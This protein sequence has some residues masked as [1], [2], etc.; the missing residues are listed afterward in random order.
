MKKESPMQSA[1]RRDFLKTMGLG[2]AA[3]AF[4]GPF[5]ACQTN[6]FSQGGKRPN[7]LF[8]F[9]DD[10]TF[11]SIGA[12]NNPEIKTPNMDRLVKRG[13]TFTHAFNQGSFSGAVCIASRA[14]LNTGRHLWNTGGGGCGDY[15]LWAETLRKAGYDTFETGKW[16]NGNRTFARSFTHGATIF[17]GGMH[18]LDKGGH[19]TPHVFDFDPSGKY[20]GKNKKVLEKHS[21]ELFADSA[22]AF[23]IEKAG[24]S[25][26]PF[27][28]YVSF[29]APHDPKQSPKAFMDKYP[30]ERMEV[31]PNFLSEHP[32]DQGDHKIRDEMLA[33]FPRTP[34]VVQKHRSDYYAIISHADAQIGRILDAL[35]GSGQIDNTIIIFSADHGLAVGQHGLMGKQNMYDHSMRVP[36]IMSGPGLPPGK[37]INAMVYLHSLFPTTC[38]MANVPIPGTVQSKSLVPLITGDRD[39]IH[40]SIYGAY[41]NMQR[42]IRTERYKLIQYPL[43]RE[44]QLFDLE[45]DP[46]ETVN[47]AGDSMYA[48]LIEELGVKMEAWQK[49]AGDKLDLEK[50]MNAPKSGDPVKP[51]EKGAM[52]LGP[53]RAVTRGQL[54]YQ[55][56]RNNLGAWMNPS[57]YPEWNL[58]GVEAGTY[59]VEF[60][61]GS[62]N[63][64]V[65]YAIVAGKAKLSG[66]TE[67]TGGI[68]TYKGFKI[69]RI[70]LECGKLKLSIRPG[71]FEGAIM[72]F[73]RLIL[74]PAG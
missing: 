12:L 54:R 52:V 31:P 23:L 74:T 38:E 40:D 50:A 63:P 30:S 9:T 26:K 53:E 21:S 51:D 6:R 19:W 42:M 59:E 70:R 3:I 71:D 34:E 45:M 24:K 35:E 28:A 48:G 22:V 27:L 69:G 37:R 11:K 2:A 65:D 57:D 1:S 60:T 55:P 7:F 25:G 36:L 72:N 44:V 58:D 14:M 46:W 16:H 41:K 8:L 43:A 33:P 20:P 29:T 68:K 10:Q 73:R 64:G 4:P 15:P 47:Q 5:A 39:R 62:I 18:G 17:M 13:V 56:D 61:Y 67:H 32:F 66:K 49:E